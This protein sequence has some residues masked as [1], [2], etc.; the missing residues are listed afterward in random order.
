MQVKRIFAGPLPNI[1][2]L[3]VA[4][5]LIIFAYLTFH[6]LNHALGNISLGAMAW[7]AQVHEWIWHGLIGGGLLYAAFLIHFGLALWALYQLRSFRLSWGE[8]VRLALGF[9]IIPLLIHHY[10]AVRWVYS[11][12][13]IARRYDVVLLNYFMM[14]PFY[15]ERQ[16]LTLFVAWIHGCLGIHYWLRHRSGYRK[17]MPALLACAVLL[18]TL[19]L[20]G[21]VQGAREVAVLARD[22]S[23]RAEVFTQGHLAD[24]AIGARVWNIELAIYG[25]YLAAIILVFVAR[26]ARSL[27]GQRGGVNITYSSGA[28]VH[29]PKGL[30]VLDASR[31]GH[32]PHASTCGGR[33]RCSTCRIRVLKGAEDVP[34]PDAHEALILARLHSGPTVRLAC[35]LCPTSNLTVMPLLPPNI[36]TAYWLLRKVGTI[37]TERMVAIMFIDIRAS[38]ALVEKR[39]PYDVIFLLNHFFEAIGGAVAEAGGAPNQFLGDGMMAIFGMD[40]EP[41]VACQQALAAI[42]P[43]FQ[44][45]NEMNRML[46]ADLPRPID[47]G[48]GVH[49]GKV[50]LGELG[51]RDRYVLTAIGDTVHVAARLQDLTKEYDCQAVVSDVV[52]ETAGISLSEFPAH[53]VQLRGRETP[54]TVR[55]IKHGFSKLSGDFPSCPI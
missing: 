37:D 40:C 45:L 28:I 54:Q 29:I 24:M 23:W 7:G 5:G 44:R 3:R 49:A 53:D 8:G 55:V 22:A 19:A 48:I 43:V 27:I 32:I 1:R 38:T 26:S 33:G 17:A 9:S 25:I 42:N 4:C 46:A 50:I 52:G 14:N 41:H 2:Q 31:L 39:L 30:S 12:Y 21:I 20:L 15:G 6:F 36:A 13:G 18:P 35:Q 34:P 16:L 51:Y 47:I 11:S 10:L